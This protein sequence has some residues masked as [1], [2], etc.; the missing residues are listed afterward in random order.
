MAYKRWQGPTRPVSNG[1]TVVRLVLESNEDA[2]GHARDGVV[3]SGQRVDEDVLERALLL[4]SE[5]VTNAV[6]HAGGNEVRVDIWRANGSIAVVVADD[7]PGFT[8]VAQPTTIADADED[9]GFG[10][11]L[12]DTLSDAWGSGSESGGEAWVWV[13]VWRRAVEMPAALP[14]GRESDPADLLDIRMVVDSV[15]NRALIALDLEGN[16]SNWGAGAQALMGY[17]T[18]ERLGRA[19]SDLYVPASAQAFALE[20]D[21]VESGGR[22]QTERW[23]RCRDGSQV[24]MEVA[25]SPIIDRSGKKRGLA[26]LLSD[27]T[28]RKRANDTNEFVI[29]ELR[30]Q[31]MTDELTGLPNRR[32]WVEELNRELARSRRRGTRLAI[33]MLDLNAFK[34]FNDEQGH[35]AGDELLR[36]VARDW[37]EA[38]RA[39]D[40]LGRFGG[41]EF[42]ITLPDCPPELALVVVGRVQAATPSGIGSSAGIASSDGAQ[43]A[44][45]LIA[46]ADAALYDAKRSG[47]AVSVA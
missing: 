10:L 25:L 29:A 32:R 36:S 2:P 33:V 23:M 20:R 5:L 17:S 24:W 26:A 13:E 42:S 21:E 38:V 44:D 28:E 9:G 27:A 3:E 18:G 46:L 45:D 7:G 31:A 37:S 34:A 30:E 47:Q 35:P 39:S 11:P 8:P 15:Q 1:A 4:T 14:A 41:D 16:V 43:T 6:L 12:I 19:L 22:Y 40:M